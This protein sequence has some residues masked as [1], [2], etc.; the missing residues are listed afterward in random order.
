MDSPKSIDL[1]DHLTIHEVEQLHATLVE[2][3]RSS[4]AVRLDATG[5]ERIDVAG[6]QLLVVAYHD[7]ESKALGF[8]VEA[9]DRLRT[10]AE[11]CG[12]API[13]EA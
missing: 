4:E 2:A 3:V 10:L 12:I 7:F 8:E 1:G 5:L 13:W 6:L 11:R 9:G